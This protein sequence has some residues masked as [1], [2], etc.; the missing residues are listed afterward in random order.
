[1]GSVK[2]YDRLPN[3]LLDWL[4]NARIKLMA[5]LRSGQAVDFFSAHLPVLATW[6]KGAFPVNLTVKGIGLIPKE[7]ILTEYSQS[8]EKAF[9]EAE[10]SGWELSL[11]SRMAALESLYS[12]PLRFDPNVLGG[13]EIFAGQTLE[14]LR[15]NSQASLLFSGIKDVTARFNYL[16]FQVNGQVKILSPE[17]PYFRFLLAARK[18][19]E[20]DRFHL[21]Q[22]NYPW[23]YLF[24]IQEVIDKSPWI[25]ENN[26]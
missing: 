7:K 4:V 21:P 3:E 14:N 24:C 20:Y 5:G 17:S 1:M 16:S 10:K 26:S 23:G 15:E 11:D 9:E 2:R 19:F 18:L 25:K 6:R 8:F 22:K 12:D 13:L